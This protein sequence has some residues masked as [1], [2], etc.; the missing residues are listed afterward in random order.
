MCQGVFTRLAQKL[1]IENVQVDDLYSIDSDSLRQFGTVYGVVFLF[2][3][4]KV[5]REHAKNGNKPLAGQYDPEYLLNGI[6]FGNQT[7]QNACATQALLNI[8][9]NKMEPQQLGEELS[10]FR[11][12]VQ[13]FDGEMIGETISNSD[14]IRSVHNSFSAPSIIVDEDPSKP[15]E[16]YDDKNDG[17]FHFVGYILKNGHIY[18]LDG[19]KT[20]PIQHAAC[21]SMDQFYELLPQILMERISKYNDELRFSSLVITNDKLLYGQEI[22]DTMLID[23]EL[24]KRQVWDKEIEQ[25]KYD[26]TNFFVNIIKSISSKSSDKE[27]EQLMERGREKGKKKMY[28]PY[29]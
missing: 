3:Y 11:S 18:E 21:E 9:L 26:Y 23:T 20:Y 16:D 24:N 14:Q 1:G 5:D 7:I 12:F 27:W 13:G 17:L 15:P 22:G 29:Q 4:G 10:N 25:R 28:L 8:L 19:L 6:F 2:K